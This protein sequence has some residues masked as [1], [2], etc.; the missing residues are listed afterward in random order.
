MPLR[1]CCKGIKIVKFSSTVKE[2]TLIYQKLPNDI[3]ERHVLLLDPVLGTGNLSKSSYRTS[4]S[5]RSSRE[6][7]YI[8]NLI[9]A[10]EGIHCV[11]KRFPSLKIVTSEIDAAL[12]RSSE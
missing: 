4:H 8:L 2:T 7:N 3:S 9:S 11:C 1:A 12:N 6:S 10:P 5:K